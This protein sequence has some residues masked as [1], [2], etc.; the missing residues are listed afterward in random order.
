MLT[1]RVLGFQDEAL[2]LGHDDRLPGPRQRSSRMPREERA[3]DLT[4]AT[5]QAK[6]KAKLETS[7]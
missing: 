5:V 2:S 6:L 1:V 4:V 3:P 7:A